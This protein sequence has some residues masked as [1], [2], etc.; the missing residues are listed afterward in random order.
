MSEIRI[1]EHTTTH[2]CLV[3]LNAGEVS[4]DDELC[5]EKLDGTETET[6]I[7]EYLTE[8]LL[9]FASVASQKAEDEWKEA[10]E[11]L[12]EGSGYAEYVPTSPGHFNWQF[13]E[14][15]AHKIGVGEQ[16]LLEFL[17]NDACD[18]HDFQVE[19]EDPS[20]EH[21]RIFLLVSPE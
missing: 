17:A 8:T 20:D 19:W 2:Y 18:V 14:V 10:W 11:T 12:G 3:S 13:V 4:L 7:E 6:T 15:M 16:I 21:C 5:I 1:R 9:P